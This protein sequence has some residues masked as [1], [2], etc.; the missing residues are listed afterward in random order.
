MAGPTSQDQHGRVLEDF[1]SRPLRPV[2]FGAGE[3]QITALQAVDRE[4]C[5]VGTEDGSAHV[6]AL[7]EDGR[8]VVASELARPQQSMISSFLGGG[9]GGGGRQGASEAVRSVAT[10]RTDGTHFVAALFADG[11]IH[12]WRLRGDDIPAAES[13]IQC[14][15]QD[16]RAAVIYLQVH[17]TGDGDHLCVIAAVTFDEQTNVRMWDLNQVAMAAS[18]SMFSAAAVPTEFATPAVHA[19]PGGEHRLKDACVVQGTGAGGSWA[20]VLLMDTPSD[21]LALLHCD[22]GDAEGSRWGYNEIPATNDVAMS[23]FDDTALEVAE[24]RVLVSTAAGLSL[25]VDFAGELEDASG[26]DG[27]DAGDSGSMIATV[28]AGLFPKEKVDIRQMRA[29]IRQQLVADRASPQDVVREMV[30]A[31]QPDEE[32][33]DRL[34]TGALIAEIGRVLDFCLPEGVGWDFEQG[35]RI[36][37]SSPA[38]VT[39]AQGDDDAG[40]GEQLC[41]EIQRQFCK[42]LSESRLNQLIDALFAVVFMTKHSA[43]GILSDEKLEALQDAVD[44]MARTYACMVHISNY[45]VSAQE[46][47]DTT[48]TRQYALSGAFSSMGRHLQTDAAS[49]VPPLGSGLETGL[50]HAFETLQLNGCGVGPG[51]DA[52]NLVALTKAL[53]DMDSATRLLCPALVDHTLESI[54]PALQS[55]SFPAEAH[56]AAAAGAAGLFRLEASEVNEIRRIVG[57]AYCLQGKFDDAYRH[58]LA[59]FKYFIVHGYEQVLGE[60]MPDEV[61]GIKKVTDTILCTFEHSRA[62]ADP[63]RLSYA[64]DMALM[65]L[66]ML[67]IKEDVPPARRPDEAGQEW[68]RATTTEHLLARAFGYAVQIVP[69]TT[70][71]QDLAYQLMASNPNTELRETCLAQLL[72]EVHKT[73]SAQKSPAERALLGDIGALENLLNKPLQT[74]PAVGAPTE[75]LHPQLAKLILARA[76][77]GDDSYFK[78]LYAF[79]IGQQNYS[80]AAEAMYAMSECEERKVRRYSEGQRRGGGGGGGGEE[81]NH[82]R[83]ARSYLT[84]A[85]NALRLCPAGGRWIEPLQRSQDGGNPQAGAKRKLKHVAMAAVAAGRIGASPE[86]AAAAA[87][88]AAEGARAPGTAPLGAPFAQDPVLHLVDLESKHALCSAKLRLYERSGL[89]HAA[90]TLWDPAAGDPAEQMLRDTVGTLLDIALDTLL[91]STSRTGVPMYESACADFEAASRLCE[92]H[93]LDLKPVLRALAAAY[94]NCTHWRQ[95]QAVHAIS[96][97]ASRIIKRHTAACGEP[98]AGG[99]PAQSTAFELGP[100][101]WGLRGAGSSADEAIAPDE[102]AVDHSSHGLHRCLAACILHLS[103]ADA[104]GAAAAGGGQG[105][106]EQLPAWLKHALQRPITAMRHHHQEEWRNVVEM[107]PSNDGAAMGL[108]SFYVSQGQTHL[109]VQVLRKLL[110]EPPTPKLLDDDEEEDGPPPPPAVC[111]CQVATTGLGATAMVGWRPELGETVFAMYSG[112]REWHEA[113]VEDLDEDSL[114]GHMYAVAYKT[115]GGGR[116]VWRSPAELR[117]LSPAAVTAPLLGLEIDRVIDAFRASDELLVTKVSG[118]GGG[119]GGGNSGP[120]QYFHASREV[121]VNDKVIA[122]WELSAA[123]GMW[124]K[125]DEPSDISEKLDRLKAGDITLR[126]EFGREGGSLAWGQRGGRMDSVKKEGWLSL[127]RTNAIPWN[128]V[129]TVLGRLPDGDEK[130]E[131]AAAYDRLKQH[132]DETEEAVAEAI[133][134][135]HPRLHW[136]CLVFPTEVASS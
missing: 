13:K 116:G 67:A 91:Q 87:A 44:L 117:P 134:D 7:R 115:G 12:V 29:T 79:Y 16:D 69:W 83:N 132:A 129:S 23:N 113:V 88:A 122:M 94:V 73:D 62:Q 68:R 52:S 21:N 119:G 76:Q 63:K 40:G 50:K 101:R 33:D 55:A 99:W 9:G 25:G 105:S 118:G 123:D 56:A 112:D 72:V 18:G 61:A 78:T 3:Y 19:L 82:A 37:E 120:S 42:Q 102:P 106:T 4:R 54:A 28:M 60:R 75:S 114:D 89:H 58:L 48:A 24:N 130:Q 109:A 127:S 1:V 2:L 38:A 6:L 53:C 86:A 26:G 81:Y 27:G 131:L 41:G 43:D 95:P 125:Y 111:I 30:D 100:E 71:Y 51:D 80:K 57:Q 90:R 36:G 136:R 84:V 14:A 47:S 74:I 17:D 20:A 70:K 93:R 103:Q 98:R 15:S 22:T 35:A 45:S 104:D 97:M 107:D 59:F 121:Q 124:N 46:G 11:W 92:L 10:C 32:A 5:A 77:A 85:I 108:L 128:L 110:F 64:L 66:R 135:P 49:A 133:E 31:S 65:A 34:D 96:L 8:T 39:M 126:I